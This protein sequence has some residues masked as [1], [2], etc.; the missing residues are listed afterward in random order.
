[1]VPQNTVHLAGKDAE[2]AL[3]L[4]DVLEDHDDIQN[5]YAN[6]DVDVDQSAP[7]S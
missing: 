5:V 7:A 2:T 4:I 6:V 3:K 1:M